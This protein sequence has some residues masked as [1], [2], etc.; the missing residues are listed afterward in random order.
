MALLVENPHPLTK[1]RSSTLRGSLVTGYQIRIRK[2]AVAAQVV[3]GAEQPWKFSR[4]S[5]DPLG[6]LA[7]RATR[8]SAAPLRCCPLL[9]GG[10]LPSRGF[11]FVKTQPESAE[12][13]LGDYAFADSV[14]H[15]TGHCL[16][17]R[18]PSIQMTVSNSKRA[19]PLAFLDEWFCPG[20]M[21]VCHRLHLPLFVRIEVCQR[22]AHLSSPSHSPLPLTSGYV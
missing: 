3:G 10:S 7:P 20:K 4:Y 12:C 18:E 16:R 14:A 15:F 5:V 19:E 21:Q 6:E 9:A 11:K 1:M 22:A 2:L 8:D 17:V 13:A